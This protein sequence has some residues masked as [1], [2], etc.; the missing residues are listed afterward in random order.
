MHSAY[1]P[2]QKNSLSSSTFLCF[3]CFVLVSPVDC[4]V[5]WFQWRSTGTGCPG[6]LWSLLLWRYSRPSWTRC[7][8]ACCRWPCLGRRVGLDDPQRS[9]PTPTILWFCDS[10][11]WCCAWIVPGALLRPA[12]GPHCASARDVAND[13]SVWSSVGTANSYT[14]GPGRIYTRGYN[15]RNRTGGR[16]WSVAQSKKKKT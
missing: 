4:P 14:T 15:N 5:P 8:A 7:C 1:H 10:Q 2:S 12:W 3:P 13:G 16:W 9:L 6:R 11:W